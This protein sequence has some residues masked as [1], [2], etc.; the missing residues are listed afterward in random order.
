MV[1][2][3]W[4]WKRCDAP[5][6]ASHP[7]CIPVHTCTLHCIPRVHQP[8]IWQANHLFAPCTHT[9]KATN[10][11]PSCSHARFIAQILTSHP[12]CI[13]IHAHTHATVPDAGGLWCPAWQPTPVP[14][15]PAAY[16]GASRYDS[17]AGRNL[18]QV[19]IVSCACLLPGVGIWGW[20]QRA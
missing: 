9:D 7:L 3:E 18:G 19:S 10:C 13:P 12:L 17:R 11:A 1:K 2:G 6:Q 20:L 8:A 4:V 5:P 15:R 14:P 16:R